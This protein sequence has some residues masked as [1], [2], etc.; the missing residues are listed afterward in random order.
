M[1]GFEPRLIELAGQINS[2]MPAF[3]VSRIAD[4]LNERQK[5]LNGSKILALGV[6]YKRDTSDIR[7]SPAIEILRGLQEKG[8]V[9]YFSDPYVPS[10]EIDGQVIKSADLIPAIIQSM[11]CVIVLTDHTA[12]DYGMI[13]AH[14]SLILDTRNVLRDFSSPNTVSL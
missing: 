4:V 9:I 6:T 12:F 2:Q 1:N 5:S 13:A 10:L 14:A 7:E 11:D 8:A 3:T